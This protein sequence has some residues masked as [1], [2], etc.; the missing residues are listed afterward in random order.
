[1][2]LMF[3]QAVQ[4][5]DIPVMA[6]YLLLVAVP[7]RAHQLR[8]RLLYARGR[9][10]HPHRRPGAPEPCA[11]DPQ[12]PI[13]DGRR[14]RWRGASSRWRLADSDLLAQLPALASSIV[15]AA[16]VTLVLV[17][18]A[19][20]APLIAPHDPLRPA[21]RSACSTPTLPP[22]W[23]DGR[24]RRASCSAPTT[25]AATSS[26]PSSTAR[27]ISIGVGVLLGRRRA[28]DRGVARAVRRLCRRPRSTR[29]SCASPTCSSPSRRS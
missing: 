8:R 5:A 16:L 29:R 1:M 3:I 11:T 13:R 28:D 24:R 15:V 6:A 9:S 12:P 23:R 21:H 22:A 25:R 14:R 26:P 27:G 10:A 7:V 19:L 17:L 2:G 18:A 4:N 20:L